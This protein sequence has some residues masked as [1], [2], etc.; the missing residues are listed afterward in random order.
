MTGASL[1]LW[2]AD[3]NAP[4]LAQPR[5]KWEVPSPLATVTALPVKLSPMPAVM[6]PTAAETGSKGCRT[7]DH[8]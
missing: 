6:T 4:T 2:G 5:W 1:G 8:T 3:V 7:P